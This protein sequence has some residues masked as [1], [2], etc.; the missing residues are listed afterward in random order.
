MGITGELS[1]MDEACRPESR[2]SQQD[3]REGISLSQRTVAAKI[4]CNIVVA[5]L[6]LGTLTSADAF[7]PN[8]D[9]AGDELRLIK[10]SHADNGT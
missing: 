6:A 10:T 3:F 4:V 7:V 8:L 9:G 1:T 2:W 5:S